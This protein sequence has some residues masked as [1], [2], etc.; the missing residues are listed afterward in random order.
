MGRRRSKKSMGAIII[1]MMIAGHGDDD[2]IDHLGIPEDEYDV[3]KLSALT[4]KAAEYKAKP[5]EHL[6]VEYAVEAAR[7]LRMLNNAIKAM[8]E[9]GDPKVMAALVA[10]VRTRKDI[11]DGLIAQ[12][13][14][15]GVIEERK[16]EGPLIIGGIAFGD[17]RS[18]EVAK[19]AKAEL[20]QLGS[21]V[22][23]ASKPIEAIDVP[24]KFYG[25]VGDENASTH[26]VD[27]DDD[28]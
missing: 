7:S 27:D 21:L 19:L 12:G 20:A 14:K 9:S 18:E 1:D 24:P 5:R 4:A 2:I 6:Y 17:L 22:A 25:P 23:A 3:L 15:L 26:I 11:C 28:D 10:A 16:A 13:I 8:E